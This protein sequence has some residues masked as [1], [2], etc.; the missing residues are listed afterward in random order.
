MMWWGIGKKTSGILSTRFDFCCPLLSHIWHLRDRERREREKETDLDDGT[1]NE[2]HDKTPQVDSQV[3][4]VVIGSHSMECKRFPRQVE[5]FLPFSDTRFK[6]HTQFS[7]HSISFKRKLNPTFPIIQNGCDFLPHQ[8][9]TCLSTKRPMFFSTI[10]QS[11]F[12]IGISR[13]R[14]EN[15]R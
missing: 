11:A 2:R 7:S 14:P 5:R 1:P 12:R 13:A 15:V 10:S 9:V 8:S 6:R 3:R 4:L